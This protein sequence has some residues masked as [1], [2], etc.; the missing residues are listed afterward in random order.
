[1]RREKHLAANKIPV[2]HRIAARKYFT[3]TTLRH[4]NALYST[5][6]SGQMKRREQTAQPRGISSG[7]LVKW[8]N[9][10]AAVTSPSKKDIITLAIEPH[11]NLMTEGGGVHPLPLSSASNTD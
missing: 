5:P 1:M 10:S 6:P 2:S 4:Q 11:V 7:A 9:E 8:R 3:F